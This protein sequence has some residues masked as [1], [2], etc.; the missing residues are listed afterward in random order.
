RLTTGNTLAASSRWEKPRVLTTYIACCVDHRSILAPGERGIL[1]C[2]AATKSQASNAFNFIRGAID[3]SPALRRLIV[4]YT[5]DTLS[6][7]TN[8]D[9]VVRTA[10]FRS[11]RGATFIA[12]ICD[13]IAF[14]RTEDNS[15]NARCRDY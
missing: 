4:G 3:D 10:A 6:L 13:E 15:V 12:V 5:A 14:F 1:P 2:L 8:V 11:I 9:V 7:A